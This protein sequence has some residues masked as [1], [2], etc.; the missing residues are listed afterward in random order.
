[1]KIY[2]I[3][4]PLRE[5]MHEYP[6]NEGFRSTRV[7]KMEEG[8]IANLTFLNMSAHTGTHIDA[9]LHFIRDGGNVGDIELE[10]MIGP[11]RVCELDVEGRIEK[12]HLERLGLKRVKRALFK[13]ANSRLWGREGFQAEYIH[14][15]GEAAQYLVDAGVKLV[16]IDYLSV[17]RYG[18]DE[19]SPHI[20]LLRSGVVLLEGLDLSQVQPGDY[21]LVALPLKLME[22]EGAPVRAVLMEG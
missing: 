5:G 10:V 2:D 16:G 17:E 8:S 18:G 3:S 11:A 6:G 15:S 1:M 14:L 21:R 12:R 20:L 7:L 9:P 13:T 22:A 19:P 4:I